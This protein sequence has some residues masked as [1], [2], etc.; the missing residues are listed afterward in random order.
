MLYV[1]IYSIIDRA[2]H[3]IIYTCVSEYAY[4]HDHIDFENEEM[5]GIGI[6]EVSVF[7][8]YIDSS[9]KWSDRFILRISIGKRD[10]FQTNV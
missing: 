8:W 6:H 1:F 5:P 7:K 10:W 9:R 2:L 3:M 4:I